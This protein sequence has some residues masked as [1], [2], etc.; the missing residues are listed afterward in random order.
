VAKA[1]LN[2]LIYE[3]SIPSAAKADIH[4]AALAA[5][6]KTRPFKARLVQRLLKSHFK[7]QC[8]ESEVRCFIWT[9]QLQILRL[10]LEQKTL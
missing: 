9:K 3:G 1:S 5:R 2:E 4:F 6:L 7:I 10:R 8:G